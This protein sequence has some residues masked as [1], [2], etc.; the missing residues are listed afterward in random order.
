VTPRGLR[1]ANRILFSRGDETTKSFMDFRTR[2]YA[3]DF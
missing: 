1:G 2:I 3:L